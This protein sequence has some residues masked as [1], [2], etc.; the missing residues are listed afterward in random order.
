MALKELFIRFKDK[1]ELD[2]FLPKKGNSFP[3]PLFWQHPTRT[4]NFYSWATDYVKTFSHSEQGVQD[5]EENLNKLISDRG[6]FI[7]HGYFVRNLYE[8][9]VLINSGGKLTANP[10]FDQTLA[11]MARMHERGDLYITTIRELLDYWVL[12]EN[13]SFDYMPDGTI[14]I[15]NLNDKS[16]NGFSLAIEAESVKIDGEIPKCR[17]SGDDTVFWFDI[18][19][20][21]RVRLNAE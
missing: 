2:S 10:Y 9:G 19:A 20:K 15:N 4:K 1:G 7:N 16:I 14:Y 12:I 13:I 5:E 21:Q 3:T 17:R 6:I 8:D 18:P 11:I